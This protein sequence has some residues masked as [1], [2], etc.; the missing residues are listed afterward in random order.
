LN[1]VPNADQ[2]S[3]DDISGYGNNGIAYNTLFVKDEYGRNALLFNGQNSFVEFEH[4]SALN[5][6]NALTV[7]IW[8]RTSCSTRAKFLLE[9]GDPYSYGIYLTSNSTILSF[10]VRLASK[11]IVTASFNGT[12]A[13]NRLYDAVGV[14]DGRHVQLYVNGLLRANVDIGFEDTIAVSSKPLWIGTWAKGS[15]F[16]GT[17]YGAQIYNRALSSLEIQ[18]P[19]LKDHPYGKPVYETVSK[20]GRKI[21]VYQVEGPITLHKSGS[22]ISVNDVQVNVSNYLLPVLKINVSSPRIANLTIFVGTLRFS[23]IFDAKIDVGNNIL[24]Y[25]FEYKLL[26]GRSYGF[27]VADKCTVIII[28][29]D[30]GIIYDDTFEKSQLTRNDL[31]VYTVLLI[32][33]LILYIALSGNIFFSSKQEKYSH[34]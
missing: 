29:E 23:K 10:Y 34:A 4:N 1:L 27:Y 17:I 19:Y 25:P 5:I 32:S 15:F 22:D 21:I 20:E 11:G 31:L 24:E 33:I 6:T 9:K 28:D 8:F 12:F 16:N 14:F 7:R 26:D 2:N 3:F 18:L 30:G 13:D